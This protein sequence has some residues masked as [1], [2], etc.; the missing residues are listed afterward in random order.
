[1]KLDKATVERASIGPK[2]VLG[3]E[4]ITT[5]WRRRNTAFKGTHT[6]RV[7]VEIDGQVGTYY[8]PGETL[9]S[10]KKQTIGTQGTHRGKTSTHTSLNDLERD[11]FT[12]QLKRS[13]D[14]S[15]IF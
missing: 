9:N 10:E 6:I 4:E 5:I 8:R 1:M 13:R 3:K 14:F 7:R 2:C 15:C 11:S 12:L